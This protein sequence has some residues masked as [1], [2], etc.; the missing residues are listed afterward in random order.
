M[1]SME[2]DTE[3]PRLFR[4][5]KHTTRG[6][7]PLE[8]LTIRYHLIIGIVR[9]NTGIARYPASVDAWNTPCEVS[10]GSLSHLGPAVQCRF[11][12][13]PSRIAISFDYCL[14][15]YTGCA[16]RLYLDTVIGGLIVLISIQLLGC[17]TI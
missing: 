4:L 17:F 10:L 13:C 6:S 11:F 15:V 7:S 16:L 9:D 14:C 8:I 1:P 12:I 2:G 5:S 3:K